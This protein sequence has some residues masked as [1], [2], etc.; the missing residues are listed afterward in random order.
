M[1]NNSGNN[2]N[3]NIEDLLGGLCTIGVVGLVMY[4]IWSLLSFVVQIVFHA[5]I[6]ITL[7]SSVS[8][9]IIMYCNFYN[10]KNNIPTRNALYKLYYNIERGCKLSEEDKII[11]LRFANHCSKLFKEDVKVLKVVD[12]LREKCGNEIKI[13]DI[14]M[15]KMNK[16]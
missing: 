7:A 4:V 11:V 10:K 2:T 9:F 5:L 8:G 12:I 14:N 13:D 1:D 3:V 6:F 16:Y 15:N